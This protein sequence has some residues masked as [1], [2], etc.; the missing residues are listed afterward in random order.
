MDGVRQVTRE[1][2][3]IFWISLFFVFV[4]GIQLFGLSGSTDDWFAWTIQPPLTAAFLGAFYLASCLINIGGLRQREWDRAGVPILGVIAFVWAM[5]VATLLDLDKFH[6]DDDDLI[7]AF[8]AWVWLAV[9]VLEPPLLVWLYVRQ[10]RA[11]GG[12]GPCDADLPPWFR[13][14]WIALGSVLVVAGATL[15]IAPGSSDQLW[16]WTLTP[17]TARATGATLIGIGVV[18]VCMGLQQC[19]ARVRYSLAA[20]LTLAV[21]VG[22]ALLR[23]PE[24]FDSASAAG[25]SFLVAL[26]LLLA[27]SAYG[28]LASRWG[29]APGG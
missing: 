9:Y 1:M 13:Y 27:G 23:Y 20:T 18:G 5:L 14:Y 21:L 19:W 10:L 12:T 16:A 8:A 11:P 2:R 6:L 28:V 4:A 24:T 26:A 3:A 15:F 22:V 17:L 7:P 25:I 29:R